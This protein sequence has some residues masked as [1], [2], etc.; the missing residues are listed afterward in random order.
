MESS[1]EQQQFAWQPLTPR[2]VA[3][4]AGA[5]L[6]R[7]LVVQLIVA[8]LAA[9]AL[10]WF[11]HRAWFPM[12]GEA[13]GRLPAEGEIRAGA[14]DWRGNSPE[15]LAENRFLALAVDLRHEG[16]ARSPAHLA[17]EF[18][19]RDIKV[20]SLFGFVALGYPRDHVIAFNQAEL[21]PWWGAWSPAILALT[22]GAVAAGLMLSWAGL[23]TLYWLP[24]WLVGLYANRDLSLRGSWRLAG[25]ALMPGALL[26]TATI[27]CYGVRAL[28]LVHLFAAAG[29]HLAVGWVYLGVSPL[30]CRRHPAA[31]AGTNPCV[32]TE[33][34]G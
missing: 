13:I 18:G 16:Q 1:A 22:A 27:L 15:V 32:K 30:Y 24:V 33:R 11:L 3:A 26:F 19:Q 4:F 29:V 28:D 8:L 20:L 31:G 25:A 5:P 17:L 2:G 21:T 23:A 7:V 12:I 10:V 9:A 14:L 6:G 34:A